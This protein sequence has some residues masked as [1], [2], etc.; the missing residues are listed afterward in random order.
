MNTLAWRVAFLVA[1]AA[2]LCA[3]AAHQV[4]FNEADFA[5]FAGTGS[6]AV[7]GTA[8]RVSKD[9]ST[10]IQTHG[11]VVKLFPK[12][13]YTDEIV[14]RKYSNREWLSRSDARL[15]KYVRRTHPDNDGHFAFYH[16]PPGEYYV[17]S[18][19]KWSEKTGDYDENGVPLW[20]DDD[21]WLYAHVTVK[22]GYTT[23]VEGWDQGR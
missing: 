6:G 20:N 12:T 2:L 11:A 9:N 13:T 19:A 1:P 22:N 3:C 16:L 18:H 8:F 5:R 21:Q 15:A 10:W 4:P 23:T 7:N 17:A 14:E